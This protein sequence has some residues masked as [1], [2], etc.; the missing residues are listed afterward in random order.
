MA[1]TRQIPGY[2]NSKQAANRLGCGKTHITRLCRHGQIKRS[3][4]IGGAW[5][6]PEDQFE[7][8]RAERKV[9]VAIPD[10]KKQPESRAERIRDY[11]TAHIGDECQ[12]A[13]NIACDLRSC[14][15]H[16]D[17]H[18]E[19]KTAVPQIRKMASEQLAYISQAIEDLQALDEGGSTNRAGAR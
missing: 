9:I 8:L 3:E 12:Q 16:P 2:I 17:D 11:L 6:I 13:S 19:A 10:F 14:L 1:G 4:K 7:K 15:Q 5:R 18:P